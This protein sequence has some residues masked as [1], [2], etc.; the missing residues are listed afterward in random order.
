MAFPGA[1]NN[2]DPATPDLFD[3][4][5]ITQPPIGIAH[6]DFSEHVLERFLVAS[7][8]AQ[9]LMQQTGQTETAPHA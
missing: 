2:P 9:T 1:I 4:L 5:I 3:N 7:I 6:V 8:S